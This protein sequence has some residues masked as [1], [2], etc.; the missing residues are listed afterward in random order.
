MRGDT[1]KKTCPR[2]CCASCSPRDGKG[3]LT[4]PRPPAEDEGKKPNAKK[5]SVTVQKNRDKTRKWEREIPF[6]RLRGSVYLAGLLNILSV[7]GGRRN[8][9]LAGGRKN[10][11][12]AS[13]CCGELR[14][15][16]T[17]ARRS[18]T[19]S[20]SD[21]IFVVSAATRHPRDTFG[22]QASR[23]VSATVDFDAATTTIFPSFC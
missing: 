21:S 23:A 9:Q 7:G 19:P 16:E 17:P 3:Y 20:V 15:T 4:V 6:K 1:L 12:T 14:T 8:R 11:Q 5:R 22:Q 2:C 10:Q 13:V 18:Q